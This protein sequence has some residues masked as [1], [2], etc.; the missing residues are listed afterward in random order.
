MLVLPTL[1]SDDEDSD[2]DGASANG[3]NEGKGDAGGGL[4]ESTRSAGESARSAGERATDAVANNP[5]VSLVPLPDNQ[6]IFFTTTD[7]Y[8]ALR[9]H[10]MLA[11][12]LAAARRLCREA[13][14]SRQPVVACPQEVKS[15]CTAPVWW[16][17]STCMVVHSDVQRTVPD[18][19]ENNRSLTWC[20]DERVYTLHAP[21][22]YGVAQAVILLGC[23]KYVR[24]HLQLESL[25]S[26][27][28]RRRKLDSTNSYGIPRLSRFVACVLNRSCR[29][30]R[31]LSSAPVS[32]QQATNRLRVMGSRPKS[33]TKHSSGT[34]TIC[35][36]KKSALTATTRVCVNL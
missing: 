25:Y 27:L 7:F 12:R 16:L 14:S 21:F 13:G 36:R 3:Q 6:E 28:S 15:G 17:Y 5:G 24:G 31:A 20:R 34:C 33:D 23:Y 9:M 35:W 1:S 26:L 19:C 8:L 22:L 29:G 18:L 4:G 32:Q 30:V 10:H 2:N 11:E